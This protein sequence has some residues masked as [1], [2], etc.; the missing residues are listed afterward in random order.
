MSDTTEIGEARSEAS[1]TENFEGKTISMEE[2]PSVLR[3]ASLCMNWTELMPVQSQTIP[4]MLDGLDVMV[5]SRTGSGKTGAFLLP[6][7]HRIEPDLGA[8]QALVLVPT[9][10]LAVQVTR[11]AEELGRDAGS[12]RS[13]STVE[14]ATSPRFRVLRVDRSS[15]L[16]HPG[17]SWTTCSRALSIL[18]GSRCSFSTRRIACCPWVSTRI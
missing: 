12:G 5:Q 4:Y 15:L 14:W 11:E 17:A 10:E 7:L 3:T 13:P 2:L 1:Q 18:I 16:A 8:P 6:I 9:R